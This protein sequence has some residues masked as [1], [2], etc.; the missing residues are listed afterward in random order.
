[1]NKAGRRTAR[2][3]TKRSAFGVFER[4]T[5]TPTYTSMPRRWG[6]R[7]EPR[8]ARGLGI[9]EHKPIGRRPGQY[10]S[11]RVHAGDDGT[12][13][14]QWTLLASATEGFC[15]RSS[16][17][18]RAGHRSSSP[19][20]GSAGAVVLTGRS[21][22][23]TSTTRRTSRTMRCRS[24][25]TRSAAWFDG[26]NP[27]ASRRRRGLALEAVTEP[28]RMGW[29]S[30]TLWSRIP[31][32]T[33]SKKRSVRRPT[34]RQR[35][36]RYWRPFAS[37]TAEPDRPDIVREPMEAVAVLCP[38][39]GAPRTS[40]GSSS[41]SSDERRQRSWTRRTLLEDDYDDV[42]SLDER[43]TR[44]EGW[45]AGLSRRPNRGCCDRR[46]RR[47]REGW[48]DHAKKLWRVRRDRHQR[49]GSTR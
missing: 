18:K 40:P 27:L 31:A 15:L 6:R 36:R 10:G 3:S 43:A 5:R 42:E 41:R 28:G 11:P 47:F 37:L 20:S 23:R 49:H 32:A 13:Y 25:R 34:T 4:T 7:P 35:W 1:M 33:H 14:R 12:V 9:P 21:P 30:S 22:S 2:V 39:P 8:D 24:S 45:N 44:A 17:R 29:V 38:S 48:L 26:M 19:T 16:K 46:R